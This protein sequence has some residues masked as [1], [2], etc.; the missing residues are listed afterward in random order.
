M[1][2][3]NRISFRVIWRVVRGICRC[4]RYRS[5]VEADERITND[6]QEGDP[7]KGHDLCRP[8][9]RKRDRYPGVAVERV[10]ATGALRHLAGGGALEERDVPHAPW[11]RKAA[12]YPGRNRQRSLH[13]ATP[14]FPDR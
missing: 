14:A 4:Y 7:G 9:T 11:S 1:P 13:A 8:G 2:A 10:A 5:K 12:F 3:W 6:A